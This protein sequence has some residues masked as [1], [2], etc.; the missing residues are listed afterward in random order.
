VTSPDALA[1]DTGAPYARAGLDLPLTAGPLLC[2]FNAFYKIQPEQVPSVPHQVLRSN[3]TLWMTVT[4]LLAAVQF[5]VWLRILQEE[6]SATLVLRAKSGA[7][8]EYAASALVVSAPSSP[9]LL[10]VVTSVVFSIL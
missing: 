5:S 4:L 9:Y 6:P 1:W 8:P 3:P 7:T 10:C 2:N